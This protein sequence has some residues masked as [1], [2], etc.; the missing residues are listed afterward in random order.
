MSIQSLSIQAHLFYRCDLPGM[1]A[2]SL[3][4]IPLSIPTNYGPM[5]P[6]KRSEYGGIRSDLAT[7][8]VTFVAMHIQCRSFIPV[9]TS[10]DCAR[11]C[12]AGCRS[13]RPAR[14]SRA[15]S[16]N[17]WNLTLAESPDSVDRIRQ[18][19][20]PGIGIVLGARQPPQRFRLEPHKC[21]R[22]LKIGQHQR[23]ALEGMQF[24]P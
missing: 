21:T 18:R 12:R 13:V 22:T 16:S 17:A 20:L 10:H 5:H 8:P 7:A 1:Q 6:G 19:H 2:K 15:V 23:H 4:K 11:G 24:A 14:D 3:I 9:D